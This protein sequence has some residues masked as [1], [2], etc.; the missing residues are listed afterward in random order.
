MWG[1]G[2]G[3]EVT[4]LLLRHAFF[5]LNLHRVWL[6]VFADHARAQ[7][8]YEKVGLRPRGPAARRRLPQRPY[9]DVLVYSLL[10]RE[11]R[12]RVGEPDP[13]PPP[14]QSRLSVHHPPG[15]RL[16]LRLNLS[17]SASSGLGQADHS[18][19]SGQSLGRW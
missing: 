10:A 16:R 17:S 2:L 18:R 11:W 15:L 9:R 13:P 12:Q 14:T 4:R 3:T 7:K 1:Q 6:R 5:T 8:V 19:G